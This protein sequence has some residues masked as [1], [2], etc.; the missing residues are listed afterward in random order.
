MGYPMKRGMKVKL[1]I[2]YYEIMCTLFSFVLVVCSDQDS[3]S[4][5]RPFVDRRCRQ[6][7]HCARQV[8]LVSGLS[9]HDVDGQL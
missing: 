6:R 1:I 7:L 8:S 3:Y 4:W 2:L 5:P 9:M